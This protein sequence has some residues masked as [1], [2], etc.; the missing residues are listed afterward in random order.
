M[1]RAAAAEEAVIFLHVPKTAGT[2]LNRLIEWEYPLFEIYSID[3]VF[4][5]WSASHL[6]RLPPQRLKKIRMF[7][8]HMLFGLHK[9]LPQ[10]ASYI[11]VLRDPID[12]V[13]SAFYFMRSYMLHPLYWKFRREK[14]TI[15]DFIRRLPRENVQCKILAGA[16]YNAPCT[17]AIFEQA[18]ENLLRHFSVVG[19][20]ER[21]EESLA[22]M[23]L[24][25]GWKLSSYSS[26]NVTR[27][28][29]KKHDLSQA[30]LDL[31]IAKN[32]FDVALYELAA[33]MFQTAINAHAS[34][35]SQITRELEAVRARTQTP[36]RS[37][38]FSIRAASRK[39]INRAYSS[40]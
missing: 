6:W 19:L 33:S 8:G 1:T 35:V 25:F 29:P 31:V 26:F 34:E 38:L 37:A 3:P 22:L 40:I 18:K 16:D 30:T 32:S 21:F 15:E 2:T 39:A 11:S 24:R 12:R 13:I 9:I 36:V 4:F 20:S 14:W 17:E 27:T 28:R 5:R 23:K 7:K 10:P